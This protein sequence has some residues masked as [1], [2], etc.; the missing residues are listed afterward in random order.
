MEYKSGRESC[1]AFI[2][3][4]MND[5]LDHRFDEGVTRTHGVLP[6]ELSLSLPR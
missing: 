6:S 3:R 5:A 4:H 1:E 2:D